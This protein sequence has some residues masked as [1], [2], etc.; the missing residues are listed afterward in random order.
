MHQNSN[1]FLKELSQ[2]QV[3]IIESVAG[4]EMDEMG[5]QR[6]FV[7][8]GEEIQYT[9]K[10]IEGFAREND[11]LKKEQSAKTDPEDARKRKIQEAV[12]DEMKAMVKEWDVIAE[13]VLP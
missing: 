10:E 13:N 3:R 8:K 5:Y 7:E 6:V 2:E 12:L 4:R 9:T 11:R 1:K